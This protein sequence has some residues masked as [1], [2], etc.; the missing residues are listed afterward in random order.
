MDNI[1]GKLLCI[2]FCFFVREINA[3]ELRIVSMEGVLLE[4]AGVGEPFLVEV[5]STEKTMARAPY[6]KGL[7]QFHVTNNSIHMQTINNSSTTKY[8]YV[9]QADA[10]GTYVIGPAE[11]HTNSSVLRS[12]HVVVTVGEH[13][14][15]DK[16]YKHKQKNNDDVAIL[17]LLVDKD[18][19]VIGQK[20]MCTLRFYYTNNV[21]RL[22]QIEEPRFTNFS[23]GAKAPQ[24][25]GN[26]II[27]GVNYQ[28]VEWQWELYPEKEGHLVIPASKADFLINANRSRNVDPFFSFF[29]KPYDHKRIYSN[30][31]VVDVDSLPMYHDQVHAV[32]SFKHITA[33]IEPRV[34]KQGEALVLTIKIEGDGKF[35]DDFP[36]QGIPSSCKYYDSKNYCVSCHDNNGIPAKCFE[37]IIQG[38]E[39]GDCEIPKQRFT[40]FDVEHKKYK[41]LETVPLVVTILPGKL[42][43]S[44]SPAD[45]TDN[46]CP[47]DTEEAVDNSRAL[48]TYDNW[49]IE[50]RYS[51]PWL[52]F[53]ITC[54]FPL[55]LLIIVSI[56]CLLVRYHENYAVYRARK[57]AFRWAAKRIDRARQEQRCEAI[58]HIFIDLFVHWMQVKKSDVTQ[59]FIDRLF[60]ERNFSDELREQWHNFF[61]VLA[62]CSFFSTDLACHKD[63]YEQAQQWVS[64]LEKKL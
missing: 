4:Q 53:F 31:R 28:Y 1:V 38:M 3:L 46:S 45:T 10:L 12:K 48:N 61:V 16:K 11:I 44:S 47:V 32:G 22:E 54:F 24:K 52:W 19:I 58:Y 5:I 6:I 15:I 42:S 39:V 49:Y 27:N 29:H 18:H 26:E 43:F 25:S 33:Y 40:Y 34:A 8:T 37:Y 35:I 63:L 57:N 13:Q 51:I 55:L 59:E 64:I 9:V 56:W 41:T 20:V 23:V 50:R 17:R 36:L 21:A 60:R 14:V 2:L 7:D 62:E 30:A